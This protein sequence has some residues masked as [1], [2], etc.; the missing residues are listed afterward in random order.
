MH[1]RMHHRLPYNTTGIAN[2]HRYFLPLDQFGYNFESLGYI[3]IIRD[4]ADRFASWFYYN[5][6]RNG[7]APVVSHI[8][9]TP[10]LFCLL[11][12]IQCVSNFRPGKREILMI[13]WLMQIRSATSIL[14][15]QCFGSNKSLTF[16][17]MQLSADKLEIEM[18]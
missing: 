15:V 12:I 6:R 5:R 18:L 7:R 1:C 4:P 11:L 10:I 17:E 2:G 8:L 14:M 13:V 3:D 9:F 16:V